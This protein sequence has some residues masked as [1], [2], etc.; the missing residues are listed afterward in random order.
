MS[1]NQ[2]QPPFDLEWVESR[3]G[4]YSVHA[5]NFDALWTAHDI[6]MIF[7]EVVRIKTAPDSQQKTLLVEERAAVT[8]A[9]S[10]VKLF[11]QMMNE[12]IRQFEEKNGEIRTPAVP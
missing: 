12:V 2:L 3:H 5:N 1:D 6:R 8:M 4:V 10:E 7:G 9:W 11:A